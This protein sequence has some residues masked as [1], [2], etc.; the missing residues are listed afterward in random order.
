MASN[1]DHITSPGALDYPDEAAQP[2]VPPLAL[3]LPDEVWLLILIKLDYCALKRAQR[4]CKK[5]QRLIQDKSLD[6]KLFR[7]GPVDDE[8]KVGTSFELHPFLKRL[9]PTSDSGLR[10][11][12][13]HFSTSS[14]SHSTTQ[15]YPAMTDFATSPACTRLM[16]LVDRDRACSDYESADSH[17]ALERGDGVRVGQVFEALGKWMAREAPGFAI[18]AIDAEWDESDIVT[19]DMLLGYYCFEGWAPLVVRQQ[20]RWRRGPAVYL[21]AYSF[22]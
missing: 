14:P 16:I 9:D 2:A 13:P 19:N 17:V 10:T 1:G 15:S 12:D 22:R 20:G 4:I 21:E 8:P 11:V 18:Q 7:L 6:G 5:V 3:R